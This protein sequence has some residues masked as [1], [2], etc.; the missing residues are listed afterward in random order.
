MEFLYL[1]LLVLGLYRVASEYVL[2]AFD[3][4]LPPSVSIDAR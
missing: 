3:Q 2:C 4:A 1:L